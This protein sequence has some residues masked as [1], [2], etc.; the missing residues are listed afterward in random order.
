MGNNFAFSG[1]KKRERV[2]PS[3]K[4]ARQ[5]TVADF[6]EA[7]LGE[8]NLE[9]A[10]R[11]A[12]ISRSVR[13]Q[14]RD[15]LF[16]E[17]EEGDLVYYLVSGQIKLYKVNEEGKELVIHFVGPGELFAEILFYMKHRY[18]VSAEALEPCTL[19]GISSRGLQGL[20]RDNSEFA[21]RLIGMLAGRLK[22]FVRTIESLT[23]TSVRGRFANYLLSQVR[24]RGDRF[25]LPV[26]KGDF[27]LLLGIAP[28]TFSRLLRQLSDE[29][30]IAVSG[31]EIA[32]LVD[33]DGLGGGA[34]G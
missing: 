4:E 9:M 12:A 30:A 19:L 29:G 28:E 34:A 6:L 17:G 8:R 5:E 13:L 20:I 23:L 15:Q 18:P 21:L 3:G 1:E 11:L 16:E 26:S 22:H 32:L 33:P 7:F 25:R 27:A 31:R 10:G 2:P 14:K 24:R